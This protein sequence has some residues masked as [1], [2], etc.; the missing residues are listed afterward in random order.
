MDPP[1]HR[2][3]LAV[4]KITDILTDGKKAAP[5]K[6]AAATKQTTAKKAAPKKTEAAAPAETSEKED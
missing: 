5:K 2:Q 3:D 1:S 4:V 6:K